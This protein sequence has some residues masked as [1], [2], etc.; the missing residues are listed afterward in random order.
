MGGQHLNSQGAT[1]LSYID[2]FVGVVNTG[3]RCRTIS[4][5][6]RTSSADWLRGPLVHLFSDSSMAVMV[7]QAGRGRD[8]F[9]QSCARQL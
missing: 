5:V 1:T 6:S 2:D 7:F 3:S 4:N 8:E 9:L